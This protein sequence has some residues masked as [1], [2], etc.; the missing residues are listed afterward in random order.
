MTITTTP[1]AL[2]LQEIL[3]LAYPKD[4]LHTLRT[5]ALKKF[6]E[7]GLPERKD[8]AFQYFPL[9][10][11]YEAHLKAADESSIVD[12]EFVEKYLVPECLNACLVFVD[13]HFRS[14]LSVTENIDPKIAILPLEEAMKTFG[15]FLQARIAKQIKEEKDPFVL[16]NLA[17]QSQGAFLY[18]PPKL[19]AEQ[20][21][22]VLHVVT[23]EGALVAP[24]LQIFV[25][26]QAEA[27]LHITCAC[28]HPEGLTLGMT[29]IAIEE[30]ARLKMTANACTRAGGWHM[31]YVRASIKR[32]G[33]YALTQVSKRTAGFRKD[34]KVDLQGENASVE[35]SGLSILQDHEMSHLRAIVNHEAPHTHSSQHFKSVLSGHSQSSIE[36][37]IV[38]QK[39]AQKTEAYQLCNHL[40]L[41]DLASANTKPNL[42]I[43]ADDV[44]ASHGATVSQ[45]KEHELFYLL[46]RGIDLNEAKTLLIEG[47]C[48]EI[49]SKLFLDSQRNEIAQCLISMK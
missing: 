29:D 36:G 42:E 14:E 12:Q 48:E 31:D 39:P 26:S 33:F 44:K 23:Q 25:G 24:R 30:G 1:F 17:V 46:S 45:L 27:K 15:H 22:Q 5:N 38:V 3:S 20:P 21:I 18:I 7:L 49:A 19:I 8:E 34:V 16:L 37:K 4:V 32:D 11:F 40:I 28:Q 13:G 43:F 6:Q 35:L 41:N 10:S 47:F 2:S 9:R